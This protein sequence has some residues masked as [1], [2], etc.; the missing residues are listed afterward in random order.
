MTSQESTLAYVAVG[1]SQLEP[2]ERFAGVA[3][4]DRQVAKA[5]APPE[6]SE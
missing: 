5:F 2:D 3:K 6:E 1:R 4:R